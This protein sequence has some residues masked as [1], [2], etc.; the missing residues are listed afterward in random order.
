MFGESHA[1][2]LSGV[3]QMMCA[4]N[5]LLEILPDWLRKDADRIGKDSLRELRLRINAP[6][7]LVLNQKSVW[8]NRVIT[9]VDINFCVNTASRYSPWAATGISQG[10][11]TASGGHRIGLCGES[12]VKDG[13]SVGIRRIGSVNIRVARDFPGISDPLQIDSQSLIIL[14]APGCGKTTLLRDYSRSLAESYSI[15]VIDERGELFPEGFPRGKRMDIL[16]GCP[17][18]VGIE[19]L[20]RTMTPEYIAVDEITSEED[21]SAL[22]K[23]VGCGVKLLASAHA[24][25][26]QDF[27]N[28]PC[29]RSLMQYQLF[30]HCIVLEKDNSFHTEALGNAG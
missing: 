22:L 4:W 17:K 19:M 25:S 6:P 20:I 16:Y 27:H 3:M 14:G 23:A 26:V 9:E 1:Y 10:Y 13:I 8:L 5:Q 29:Y 7:E 18:R 30:E 15:A 24:S 12:V 28:R 2:T 11:I 21:S